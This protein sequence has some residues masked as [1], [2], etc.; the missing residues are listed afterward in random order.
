MTDSKPF[1]KYEP[2]F[3]KERTGVYAFYGRAID[4]GFDTTPSY[5]AESI[6][7]FIGSDIEPI[8]NQMSVEGIIDKEFNGEIDSNVYRM[9]DES[10]KSDAVLTWKTIENQYDGD[11]GAIEEEWEDL[12]QELEDKGVK[13]IQ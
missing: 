8:L 11:I 3:L 5:R 6:E 4:Q 10:S 1:M 9:R 13:F 2:G 12:A 7:N